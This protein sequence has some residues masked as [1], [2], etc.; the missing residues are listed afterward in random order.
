MQSS[1]VYTLEILAYVVPID[2][3][4]VLE[5]HLAKQQRRWQKVNAEQGEICQEWMHSGSQ[6][7]TTVSDV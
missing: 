7:V 6:A 3:K 4:K 5:M 1:L 2:L